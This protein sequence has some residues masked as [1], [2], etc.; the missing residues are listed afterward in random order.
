MEPS[1]QIRRG[2]P[3]DAVT[4]TSFNMQMAMETEHKRLDPYAVSAG[5]K[6]ALA[7]ENKAIYDKNREK[8][9]KSISKF[10]GLE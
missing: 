3:G 1:I 9:W 4:I 2:Q 6:A 7:D 5:V 10:M 8:S